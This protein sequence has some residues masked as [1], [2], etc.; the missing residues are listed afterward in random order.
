MEKIVAALDPR[1]DRGD[2]MRALP[3]A[4]P[5]GE[6]SA[7]PVPNPVVGALPGPD[8]GAASPASRFPAGG[9]R[10]RV[11]P[12]SPRRVSFT[13]TG[14]EALRDKLKRVQELTW[15]SNPTGRLEFAVEKLADFYLDRKDPDRRLARR[16][17]TAGTEGG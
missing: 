15:H 5:S 2:S 14:S 16:R 17:R 11:K 7:A 13:F 9:A 4:S 10:E 6:P 12:L 1:P 3:L 8:A